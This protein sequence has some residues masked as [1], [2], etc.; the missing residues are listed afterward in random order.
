MRRLLIF[1]LVSTIMATAQKT[2]APASDT[3]FPNTD[4]LN[5]MAARFAPAPLDVDLS[6]LSAGDK[7]A[8][9]KLIEAGRI[10][11]H[12]FMQQFWSGDLALYQKLQL[13]KSALGK[14]RLHYFWINKGPWS[15]IDGHKAFLPGVPAKKLAG[16]NFYPEDMTKEEFEAWA[17]T[18]YPESKEQA[19]GFFTVIRRDANKKLKMVP[20]SEAYKSD[21]AKAVALLKQA[22]ALTDNAS[23]KKFL[24]TRAAA[25]STN[26]YFESDMAWMDLDAPVDVTIG[27]YETY[28]DEL[29][30]YKAAFEAYINVRDE[31]ESARLA[32][33]GEHLQEIENNLPEDPKYRVP[34]LGA[35][36]PIRVV[37]EV[38][39]AGDGNHGV[40]TAAYN[41]PNDDKVVQ[42]KGSKRVMLKNIQEAKFKQ[43]LEPISK[44]VLQPAAQQD[45][46]FE[47]FFTHI[48][49]HELTHGLG[50][51][52]IKVNGRDTNP[53]LELKELYSAVEEAKADVTGLFALQYL[54]T[55]A[56]KGAVQAPLPHG[57]DAERKLY[58][59]YLASSFR[60]LRFGLQDSHAKGMAV[61]FNY[62]LDKG[63]FVANADGTFNVDLNKIKDAVAGLDHDLLT[64]EATG[65]YNGTKKLMSE[66][67]VLRPEVQKALERLKGVPTDIE[68]IFLTADKLAGASPVKIKTKKTK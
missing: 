3:S 19:E 16:A 61:Q 21:L 30:G 25:F 55:Q 2:P 22:A 63:A 52:Q 17:K 53:R 12:L 54:M 44:V 68:P 50:P 11:N 4:E 34:K 28:N 64:L 48:V 15:E 14:A 8:L 20:Y 23:L 33:L 40:Q 9:A 32:F 31:K 29:F 46:S 51:H 42:Q 67:M 10:V 56:D 38:F 39:A 66:M 6:A 36:A 35:A 47:L 65:D 26:N 59:T 57:P 5:Q 27:P 13:D 24:T 45:L 60:T 7:K 41:L 1:L 49:A 58:T 18:L 37:N 43:T 62:F